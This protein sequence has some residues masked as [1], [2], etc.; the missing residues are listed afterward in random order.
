[1]R[2]R[3]ADLAG[4]EGLA[5]TRRFVVE[6]NSIGHEQIVGF[7]VV[8]GVPMGR[9]LGHRVRAAREKAVAS[10]GGAGGAEHFR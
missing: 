6:Q 2:P 3:A 5:A 7:A 10:I 8:D 4:D 9:D 1:M